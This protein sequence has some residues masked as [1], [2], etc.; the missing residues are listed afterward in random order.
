MQVATTLILLIAANSAVNG[1]PRLLYFMARDGYVPRLFL[2]MGDRL[3]FTSGIVVLA[4][5]AAILYAASTA[6]PSR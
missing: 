2:R 3:A 5:P 1:F 4:V 6:R